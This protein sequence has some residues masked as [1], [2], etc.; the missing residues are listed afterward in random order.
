M[1]IISRMG[2]NSSVDIMSNKSVLLKFNQHLKVDKLWIF[3]FFLS[4]W[5][6]KIRSQL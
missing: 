2:R 5:Y 6:V 1:N 3:N 4:R